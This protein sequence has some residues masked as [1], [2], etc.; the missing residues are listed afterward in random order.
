MMRDK[1]WK[2]LENEGVKEI[3]IKLGSDI[4]N[5]YLHELDEKVEDDKL[6]EGTITEVSEKGYLLHGQVL[7]PAK[8]KISKKNK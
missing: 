2:N 4:W 6:P 8:V 7:R 1:L 3:E 5:S